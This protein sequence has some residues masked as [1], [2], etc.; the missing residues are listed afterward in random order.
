M[1]RRRDGK[2][3]PARG[4][5][6][7]ALEA[8]N[9][10]PLTTSDRIILALDLPGETEALAWAK[11]FQGR[12]GHFKIGLR[13]F[14]SGGPS[15]VARVAEHGPVFLDL[16]YHDIPN[17]VA[18]AV[19]EA[20]KL[21]AAMLTVHATGGIAMMRA[22]SEAASGAEDGR[23][24]ILAVTVLTSLESSDLTTLGIVRSPAAQASALAETA[25]FAGCDGLVASPLEI[26]LIR[27]SLGTG[28]LLVTPG[29]RPPGYPPDD[30]K[31][32]ATAAEALAAGADYLVIGRP[33]LEAADP[34]AAL[35]S[36][37]ISVPSPR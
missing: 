3:G 6:D 26:T 35:E 30:Q 21:G 14:T 19:R 28:P 11:R 22:A 29:I 34:E 36:I 2:R 20:T 7:S 33:I 27:A 17:T 18:S 23:V 37:V 24:R 8:S 32:T 16:K 5:R 25:W 4:H 12:V 9:D 1:T 31:R 13:L 10:A 15:L